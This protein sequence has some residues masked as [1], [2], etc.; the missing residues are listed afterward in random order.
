MSEPSREQQLEAI[1]HSYLQAVDAGQKPDP[2]AVLLRHPAFAEELRAFF[3]DQEKLAQFARSLDRARLDEPTIGPTDPGL[4]A[5][6]GPLT[7]EESALPTI[8]YFGDYELLEEM[9]RGGMGVVYKAKQVSLNRI[10]AL[11]M[12]LAG[13]LASEAHVARFRAEAEAAGKLDH[14]HIVP[15]YEIGQHEGQHYFSMKLIE[16][17]SL[18][19]QVEAAGRKPSGQPAG[20]GGLAPCRFSSARTSARPQESAARLVAGIARA[21]HHAHQ[22]GIL[23]RD[24]KPGNI[25]IDRQGEPHVTDFGLARPVEGDSGLTQS[26]AIVGTPSYMAPEQARAEKQLTT[27]IDV[28]SLGAILYELLTGQPPFRGDS[29]M[30]TILQVIGSEPA[31]P[32]SL[33]RAIDRDLETICLKCLDKNP[34]KRYE[35]A[36]ALADDLERW[37]AANQSRPAGPVRWNGW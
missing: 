31:P 26:G 12:I 11:K 2:E 37:L 7:G 35:S 3:A 5:I 14:P 19:T 9:G 6:S 20:T 27:A 21:V 28:Y 4:P 16:G 10:V 24:L 32:R 23:H 29:P 33:R 25:L 22:R 1:L 30:T 34:E 15:I 18:A 17:S 8:R 36:A 13:Q